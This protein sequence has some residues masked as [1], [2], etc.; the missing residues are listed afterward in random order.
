MKRQKY[1]AKNIHEYKRLRECTHPFCKELGFVTYWDDPDAEHRKVEHRCIEHV[2][3]VKE[4]TA[5]EQAKNP[6][7]YTTMTDHRKWLDIALYNTGLGKE[8][9]KH[10][11]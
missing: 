5:V 1:K 2:H 4:P 10:G 8:V 6:N 9:I 3:W 11:S 7:L